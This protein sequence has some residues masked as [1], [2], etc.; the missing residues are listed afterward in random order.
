M[1]VYE[2]TNLVNGKKYI[3]VSVTKNNSDNYLGSG[4]LLKQAIKKYGVDSFNK[5][6]LKEFDNEQ[7]ARCYE[8]FLIEK[9]NAINDKNYYNLVSGGY[10]GGVRKHP[11]SEETKRKISESHT[12]KKLNRKQVIDM[13]KITL[14]YNLKG[15]FIKYFETKADAEKEINGK[16]TKL[17]GNKIVYVKNF[18]WKYKS[19]NIENKI[20]S[21]DD[22]KQKHKN[23]L[24]I[25]NSKLNELE[26]INLV[27]DK[28]LGLTIEELSKKYDISKSCISE[29]LNGKTNKWLWEKINTEGID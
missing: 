24:A 27:K 3:G 17:N 21:Y 29:F 18:L 25:K 19:G 1:Y 13:G 6:I 4:I 12:G 9:L 7:D 5:I 22:L 8:K 14:Q 16:L 28:E 10:G 11:V 15:E 2:T 20:I 23:N 26:L